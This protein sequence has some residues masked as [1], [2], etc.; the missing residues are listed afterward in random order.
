MALG[1]QELGRR[2]RQ[3]RE[4]AGFTQSELAEELGLRHPQSVSRYERGETE[5]PQKRLRRI[6]EV[7]GKPL[8]FFLN[9]EPVDQEPTEDADTFALVQQILE[10]LGD[11]RAAVRR[12]EGQPAR[13][14]R[15][16]ERGASR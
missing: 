13:A 8:G 3:A 7:T 11:L 16:R 2:I 15:T 10:Q 14:S 9:D 4:D 12:L 5:V 6:A 1:Q